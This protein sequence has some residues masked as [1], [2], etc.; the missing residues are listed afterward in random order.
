MTYL[1]DNSL[2]NYI[3]VTIL[4]H[5]WIVTLRCHLRFLSHAKWPKGVL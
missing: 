1:F 2:T 5:K 3:K 4:I